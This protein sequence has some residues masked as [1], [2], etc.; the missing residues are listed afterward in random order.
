[1]TGKIL[2]CNSLWKR[3]YRWNLS[4]VWAAAVAGIAARGTAKVAHSHRTPGVIDLSFMSVGPPLGRETL[5][6]RWADHPCT[7]VTAIPVYVTRLALS[8]VG[9]TR[10]ARPRWHGE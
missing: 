3:K 4:T 2:T 9:P 5:G 10:R 6:S 1:M 8:I 7:S